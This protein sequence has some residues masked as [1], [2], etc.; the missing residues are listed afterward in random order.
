M[1]IVVEVGG[2]GFYTGASKYVDCQWGGGLS[3]GPPRQNLN[4]YGTAA[5]QTNGYQLGQ[6]QDGAYDGSTSTGGGGG[7]YKGGFT[8][9]NH[10]S[11]GGGSGHIGG[12]IDYNG[13]AKKTIP[14]NEYITQI[15]GTNRKGNNG[16]GAARITLIGYGI[17]L[18]NK[19]EDHYSPGSLLKFNVSLTSM[20]KEEQST[21]W[22][23]IDNNESLVD[24]HNDTGTS[25]TYADS[26]Y[27]PIVPGFYDIKYKVRSKS[28]AVTEHKFRIL[29]SSIPIIINK[30]R[31]QTKFVQGENLTL[32]LEVRDDTYI[33]LKINDG[34]SIDHTYTVPCYGENNLTNYHIVIPHYEVGSTHKVSITGVDEFGL[35]SNTLQFDV[36][37]VTNNPPLARFETKIDYMHTTSSNM[38]ALVGAKDQD[39][40]SRICMCSI[41]DYIYF[42][43]HQCLDVR[44]TDWHLFPLSIPVRNYEDGI[45]VLSVYSIDEHNA[46]SEKLE[47]TFALNRKWIRETFS[48][49]NQWTEFVTASLY[50]ILLL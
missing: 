50:V 12:V 26:F 38:S 49:S 19:I 11:G 30:S 32:P 10:G 2:N 1:E 14:G 3:G 45:H 29:V 31:F 16:H 8:Y 46:Q 5:D 39:G 41:M 4:V 27:S 35:D 22:R 40:I 44:D 37:I 43:S 18:A 33:T 6:G 15:D 47:H 20:G 17:S 21:M 9:N 36:I 28:G 24:T 42:V 23:I 7:G 34:A 48:C 13:I 25:Y